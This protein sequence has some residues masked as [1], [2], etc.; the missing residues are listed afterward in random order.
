MSE[1]DLPQVAPT[2]FQAISLTLPTIAIF[3]AL[4]G[5]RGGRENYEVAAFSISL[6]SLFLVV[7]AAGFNV[8]YLVLSQNDWVLYVAVALYLASLAFLG[9]ATVGIIIGRIRGK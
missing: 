6:A 1:I 3:V 9:V 2:L 8:S 5:G 4:G 7:L